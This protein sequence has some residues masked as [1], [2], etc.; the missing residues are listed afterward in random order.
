L[1][2]H[3]NLSPVPPS[4]DVESGVTASADNAKRISWV[5]VKQSQQQDAVVNAPAIHPDAEA[6]IAL[7]EEAIRKVDTLVALPNTA[8]TD[9]AIAQVFNELSGLQ[10]LGIPIVLK[11]ETTGSDRTRST[12]FNPSWQLGLCGVLAMIVSARSIPSNKS[13]AHPDDVDKPRRKDQG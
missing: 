1:L 2:E 12:S 6:A 8:A 13:D 4:T 10:P 5:G 7:A 11:P 3:S 9:I